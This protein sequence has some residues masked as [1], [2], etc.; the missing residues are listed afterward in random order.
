MDYI[1]LNRKAYDMLANEYDKR[2]H[3]INDDFWINIYN[4]I[5]I[6]D[7][8]NVLEIGPGNGRNINILR[9]FNSNVTAVELSKNMCHLIKTNFPETQIIN[10]NILECNFQA[11]SFDIIFISAV[12]HNFPIEDAKKLLIKI[13][14]WLKQDGFLIISTTIN[15]KEDEGVFE[16]KDYLGNICRFRHKYTKESFE[17]IIFETGFNIFKPHIIK[18]ED[19]NKL[20]Y[21]MA[22]QK[23]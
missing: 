12:I 20:W 8:S 4:E 15:D 9:Q 19:R 13:N 10:S 16:K 18:E 3:Q 17:N 22:C 23:T 7:N 11:E 21:V 1:K 6:K 14:N 5:K 2:T